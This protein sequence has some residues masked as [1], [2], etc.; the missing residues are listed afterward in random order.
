MSYRRGSIK[1]CAWCVLRLSLQDLSFDQTGFDSN[2]FR[3]ELVSKGHMAHGLN[4]LNVFNIMEPTHAGY[5]YPIGSHTPD[6]AESSSETS[7]AKAKPTSSSESELTTTPPSN[8][9]A[10]NS[11][12]T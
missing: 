5:I 2:W 1:P 9:L 11:T 7:P 4:V 12:R 3:L 6:E 10:A 8:D